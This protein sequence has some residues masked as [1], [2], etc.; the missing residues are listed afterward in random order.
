VVDRLVRAH[1]ASTD[2]PGAGWHERPAEEP[3]TDATSRDDD[4]A[5]ADAVLGGD[6]DAF[7]VLVER[8]A[9]SVIAAC[10]RIL[11]D[12]SDAEDAAQDAFLI[13]YRKLGSFRGDGPLGGWLMRIAI[14]EARDRAVRR[15]PT[16]ALESGDD[17][18]TT[19]LDVTAA[20]DDPALTV[21]SAE[22]A[23]RL[24]EAIA[25][26]PAHYGEAVRLRY[27]EDRSFA[28]IAATTGRPE[29]TVRTHLHRG[30]ARLRERL[31]EEVR[32]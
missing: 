7:R 2:S 17:G 18:W 12:P 22:R 1:I 14:R 3:T 4:R 5:L 31:G 11:G 16:T 23:A 25:E 15:R 10:R 26:L 6:R 20:G 32:L 13:A 30:L 8:E 24:R 19:T 9:P 27:I 29:P 28:E 21:E